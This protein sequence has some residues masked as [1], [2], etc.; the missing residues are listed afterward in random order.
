MANALQFVFDPEEMAESV[1]VI[2]EE[3]E[4]VSVNENHYI[5]VLCLDKSGSMSITD[6]SLGKSRIDLV[7]ECAKKFVNTTEISAFDKEKVDLC[8][9]TFDSSVQVE[10]DFAPMTIIGDDFNLKASGGTSLYTAMTIACE[11]ARQRKNMLAAKGT[12][13]FRPLVLV[14]TD[15]QPTDNQYRE[16]CKKVLA[17]RVDGKKNDL[18]ICGFGEADMPEMNSL[19]NNS[20]LIMLRNTDAIQQVFS[21][22]SKSIVMASQSNVS[23]AIHLAMNEFNNLGVTQVQNGQKVVNLNTN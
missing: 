5:I 15:G 21:M 11:K 1:P 9:I 10:K 23:D 8:V 6:S 14:L 19:C 2:Q 18:I 12:P 3:K 4:P 17:E 13:L 22:L 20:Q 7:N 16:T